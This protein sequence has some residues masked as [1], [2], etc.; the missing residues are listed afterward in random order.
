M[1]AVASSSILGPL[2]IMLLLLTTAWQ[3]TDDGIG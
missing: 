2:M 1:T 3:P